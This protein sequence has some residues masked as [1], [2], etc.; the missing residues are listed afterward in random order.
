MK[1][2]KYIFSLCIAL[3]SACVA[4]NAQVDCEPEYQKYYNIYTYGVSD[5]GQQVATDAMAK[6]FM[7]ANGGAVLIVRGT[8]YAEE[9]DDLT[10]PIRQQHE[11]QWLIVSSGIHPDGKYIQNRASGE[12]LQLSGTLSDTPFELF[13]HFQQ[14]DNG[15]PGYSIQNAADGV[16]CLQVSGTSVA[17]TNLAAR[18]RMYFV[19]DVIDFGDLEVDLAYFEDF[20]GDTFQGS[21]THGV[22][23]NLIH[24]THPEVSE[25]FMRFNNENQGGNRWSAF[26]F[27]KP[28][29]IV[30]QMVI[31]FDYWASSMT[32]A[33][34]DCEGQLKFFTG[35][36]ASTI[37]NSGDNPVTRNAVVPDAQVVFTIF[38]QRSTN[39]EPQLEL[40]AA[41]GP[42]A[43]TVT[44]GH[45][46]PIV[47]VGR[48]HQVPEAHRHTFDDINQVPVYA[49]G[50]TSMD[51]WYRIKA[52]IINGCYITFTITDADDNVSTATIPFP[53]DFTFS[54]LNG[55]QFF[56]IRGGGNFNWQ[57]R[58]DNLEIKSDVYVPS[59][60]YSFASL[61][62]DGVEA[63][64]NNET[65]MI[66]ATL[67]QTGEFTVSYQ[68][69]D[70]GAT[71]N[72]TSGTTHDFANG[73]LLI[74]VTAENEDQKL[75]TVSVIEGVGGTKKIAILS[76]YGPPAPDY[77]EKLLSAFEDF[78][79]DYL[80][81]VSPAPADIEAFYDGYDLIVLHSDV[82]G[83]QV[84]AMATR[85]MVGKKPILNLKAYFYSAGRWSWGGPSNSAA[86]TISTNVSV[87]L[88]NHQI[89]DDV[90][91]DG[92]TLTYYTDN[93]V[94][95]NAVQHT[96]LAGDNFTTELQAANN[97]LA[98]QANANQINMHEVNLNN[99]AKYLLVG[100]SFESFD[101]VSA[102]L[103]FN[104][105]TINLLKNAAHYLTNPEAYYDYENNIPVREFIY[106]IKIG[107][108]F[109]DIDIVSR[110][111]K[112][113]LKREN[114]DELG[115]MTV[116]YSLSDVN[117]KAD[118][119]NGS[120]HDFA[121]GPLTFNVTT[122]KDVIEYTIIVE[123][124]AYEGFI[125]F[126]IN[127]ADLIEPDEFELE[128]TEW[129][130]VE[131]QSVGALPIPTKP[132]YT[133]LGWNY[134]ADGSGDYLLRNSPYPHH[135]DITLYAHW[136]KNTW[137]ISFNT[138]A[139]NVDKP[140]DK[141]VLWNDPVGEL[142]VVTRP[143]YWLLEG[144]NTTPEGIDIPPTDEDDGIIA[145]FYTAA[146]LYT[147]DRD[148]TLYAIWKSG[149]GG[150]T[151]AP[152]YEAIDLNVYPNPAS[153]VITI[154]GTMDKD[155]L[156]IFD[157]SG[158]LILKTNAI[159]DSIY[160][161]ID[162]L[163]EGIYLL[164]I[165]RGDIEQIVRFIVN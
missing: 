140:D 122:A 81:A 112:V 109:A 44:I 62:I 142:P 111:A 85:A 148:M 33:S 129:A 52:E 87:N 71:A 96:T 4:V 48:G 86:G 65:G 6:G 114:I 94:P 104:D 89:F 131:R 161:R 68:L 31:E 157:I 116:L 43:G 61:S 135:T 143:G 35:N 8:T 150:T 16:R 51:N 29:N 97:V 63:A 7:T 41:V 113:I 37:D 2:K 141:L 155:V 134:E 59:D 24:F 99:E 80:A 12:Y 32:G 158:R 21:I 60:D 27:P 26:V 160:L 54:S 14:E 64:I 50:N 133:F 164:K 124:E 121:E 58:L 69:N 57:G 49:A 78:E 102:Y 130:V 40:H 67:P 3:I 20:E 18:I 154:S 151:S 132:G 84:T 125:N 23:S 28:I 34:E 107:D 77:D 159:G 136:G 145:E 93:N 90:T 39:A 91:F 74:T 156:S 72:F 137:T 147:L 165:E 17:A 83:Q 153:D 105:N 108:Y 101:G 47:A 98:T 120:T 139:P 70:L 126:D 152:E 88:Q 73:P 11:A 144:W 115:V 42:L 66:A 19:M 146:T 82:E 162:F 46:P 123:V 25:K 92:E 38:I 110:T 13:F 36:I 95:I 127:T 79:V 119:M 10:D 118:F 5:G 100:I 76:R 1:T 149:V 30:N 22:G 15:K 53:D 163:P 45:V 75:Y 103:K 55:F 128:A 9:G 117:S 56:G 106:Q 138:R